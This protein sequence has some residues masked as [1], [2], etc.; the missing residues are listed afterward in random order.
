MVR[1]PGLGVFLV[2]AALI[3][4]IQIYVD[5]L[6]AIETL[7]IYA[8]SAVLIIGIVRLTRH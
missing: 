6:S 5:G 8:A 4:L 7:G 1:G 3:F 2:A